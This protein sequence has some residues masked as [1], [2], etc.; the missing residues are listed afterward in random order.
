M[1]ECQIFAGYLFAIM[2]FWP[3]FFVFYAYVF[4]SAWALDPSFEKTVLYCVLFI[5]G[6]GCAIHIAWRAGKKRKT[7]FVPRA[8]VLLAALPV[9]FFPASTD[10]EINVGIFF[11]VSYVALAIVLAVPQNL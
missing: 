3:T 10:V 7:S 1:R 6:A 2:S 8:V 4:A 9:A 11:I 5:V